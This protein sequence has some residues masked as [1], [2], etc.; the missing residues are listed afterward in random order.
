MNLYNELCAITGEKNVLKDELMSGHTTFRIGGPA[1]YFVMPSSAG[2]IKRIIALC[3]EQD[4]P[5]YIIGNGSN[6]L[7]ADKGYRGVIIQIFKNMKDIQ[8][9]GE[10]IRAQAGALL[11][12]VAAAA[13]EA[14]LE[15]FEFAS[16]IPG[17]LGG[18]VRMNAGA[19]GGE[20]KQVLKSAEV[21]TPEGEV[22]TLP[23]EEMKMGY[24]TSIVSRMDYV[25]LGAE[26]AL[27]EGN[28]EEIRAKMDELKEKRV[29]KQ[30]L[31]FGSAGS[32]FK[33]PEGYF[34]GKLIE[35]AGLRGFRVG[36]A[37]VSEKH[38]GFVIN[39]GGATAR[40]VA[41][42]METVARRVEENS[43]VRLEPEVKKIGEF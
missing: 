41:E 28:K 25:V 10:N 19:Y 20:M 15:G 17:T 27:R 31:E 23:V 14:G 24:R 26:I 6:L 32:T 16:G 2:E 5:Y 7:V 33:R 38:C 34:A 18:A 13:Y 1:D 43:G 9:E 30:P 35:D 40:E 11:S 21:L 12:K 22:L 8:V 36:N 29:S 37:Q 4:V 3:L 39:R 42:L